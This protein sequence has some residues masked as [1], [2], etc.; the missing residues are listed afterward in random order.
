MQINGARTTPGKRCGQTPSPR[1]ALL[2]VLTSLVVL[3]L[4]VLG[5][6]AAIAHTQLTGTDP[7]DGQLLPET[8]AALTQSF[9]EPIGASAD[10]TQLFTPSGESVPLEVQA[11][12]TTVTLI[13]QTPVGS[14]THAVVW[15]VTSA[16]GH[17]VTRSF[18][19]SVSSPAPPPS[20]TPRPRHC[21]GR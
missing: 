11:M 2:V 13:P 3:M 17:P 4:T 19:F 7:A 15:Q 18:T 1:R 10:S 16:D 14:G 8:A 9:N 6:P 5:V 20:Q 12:D 21:R